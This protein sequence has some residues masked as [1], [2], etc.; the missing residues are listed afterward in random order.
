MHRALRD[1]PSLVAGA[2]LVAFFFY[3]TGFGLFIHLGY[4]DVMNTTFA[5]EPP[6]HNLLIAL[7]SPF[8][9]IYRPTGSA[10]YRLMFAIFGLRSEPFRIVTYALLLCNIYLVYRLA[11][12]LS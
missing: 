1:T 11:G 3:C 2:L 12:K 6:L 4:D 9:S 5:W 7:L 10:F 8:T